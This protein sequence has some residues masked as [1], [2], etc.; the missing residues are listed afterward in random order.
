MLRQFQ[1]ELLAGE[2][3]ITRTAD[4]PLPRLRDRRRD[5]A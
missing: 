1:P 3:R 2:I 4:H 5:A